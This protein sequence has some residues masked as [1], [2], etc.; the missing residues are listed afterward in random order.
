MTKIMCDLCG[1]DV[2]TDKHL[3]EARDY[4][5]NITKYGTP[6]DMCVECRREFR[7]WIDEFKEENGML[8][9]E[10]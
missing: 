8:K 6:I 2:Q 3:G 4:V 10:D 7:E 1:K 5:F 9:K